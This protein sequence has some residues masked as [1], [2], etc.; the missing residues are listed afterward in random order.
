M[1]S[2]YIITNRIKDKDMSLTGQIADYI[3]S[4]GRKCFLR[5]DFLKDREKDSSR[6]DPSTIPEETDCIIVLGGD[7][8]LL[9]AARDRVMARISSREIHFAIF[10]ILPP[11]SSTMTAPWLPRRPLVYRWDQYLSWLHRVHSWEMSICSGFR[12]S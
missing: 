8:T 4:H 12:P 1:K 11:Q 6:T 9:Q 2:F 5:D 7:G 3:R 10:F